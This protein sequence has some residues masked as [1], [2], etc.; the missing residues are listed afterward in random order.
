MK[1]RRDDGLRYAP[2]ILRY[3]HSRGLVTRM[4]R[5]DDGLRYAPPILRYSHARGL[6]TRRMGGAQ[7]NP[8][9]IQ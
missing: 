1:G 3:S 2:P 8:S 7:R 4:G 6:V 9:L 5:L